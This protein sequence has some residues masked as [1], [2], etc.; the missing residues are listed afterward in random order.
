MYW[1]ELQPVLEATYRLLSEHD[2]VS[3]DQVVAELGEGTDPELVHRALAQLYRAEYIGGLTIEQ[4]DWPYSIYGTEKGS[5]QA[6]GW[7][8]EGEP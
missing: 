8:P 7:P 4:Q 3:P 6:A 1:P 2:S 5:Q